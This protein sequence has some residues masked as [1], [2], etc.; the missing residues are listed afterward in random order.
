MARKET[1]RKSILHFDEE[2]GGQ[3]FFFNDLPNFWHEM[4]EFI[5]ESNEG[6][7]TIIIV[8]EDES[9]IEAFGKFIGVENFW[10]DRTWQSKGMW[11]PM[12]DRFRNSDLRFVHQLT[13]DENPDLYEIVPM[14]ELKA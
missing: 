6:Y 3:E 1:I 4:P 5:Q 14:T 11:F 8:F 12:K 2:D 13:V 7:D 9:E 10:Q